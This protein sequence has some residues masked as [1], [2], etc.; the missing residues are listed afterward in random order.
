M[1]MNY[2]WEQGKDYTATLQGCF[3]VTVAILSAYDFTSINEIFVDNM[4]KMDQ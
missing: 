4:N 1:A 2:S 3:I